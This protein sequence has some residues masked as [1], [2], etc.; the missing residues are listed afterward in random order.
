MPPAPPP[1]ESNTKVPKFDGHNTDRCSD[2]GGGVVFPKGQVRHGSKCCINNTCYCCDM[3]VALARG[4]GD[5]AAP[6][7]LQKQ[8]QEH[9][10]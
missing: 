3:G 8:Q 9:L 10:P 6:E 1:C 5:Q 7:P 2:R 4:G